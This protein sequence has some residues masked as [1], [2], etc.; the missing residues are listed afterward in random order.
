[1]SRRQVS[2]SR[3]GPAAKWMMFLPNCK[4]RRSKKD[5]YFVLRRRKAA[6]ALLEALGYSR[7][8]P[9]DIMSGFHKWPVQR[10]S[11]PCPEPQ[12]RHRHSGASGTYR[13]LHIS[14]PVEGE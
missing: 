14:Q 9:R 5:A 2:L 13:P 11:A 1:M 4:T 3:S 12:G 7:L 6:A 10:A 8:C